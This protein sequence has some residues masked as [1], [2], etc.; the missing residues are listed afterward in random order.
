MLFRVVIAVVLSLVLGC[1]STQAIAEPACEEFVPGKL[2]EAVAEGWQPVT[3]QP[4]QFGDNF[5][6]QSLAGDYL[7]MLISPREL[8][9]KLDAA[10]KKAGIN[11]QKYYCT[12]NGNQ[13]LVMYTQTLKAE[14]PAPI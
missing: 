6:L 4:T 8:E 5:I 10:F 1:V 9:E 11:P 12:Y 14:K 7:E 3:Y 13:P 2:E